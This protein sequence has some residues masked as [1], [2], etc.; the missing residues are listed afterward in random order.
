MVKKR[1]RFFCLLGVIIIVSVM[2]TIMYTMFRRTQHQLSVLTYFIAQEASWNNG[3]YG[4]SYYKDYVSR[5]EYLEINAFKHHAGS[6]Y[7]VNPSSFTI[8]MP[9]IYV[10]PFIAV[11]SYEYDC[12]YCDMN[13]GNTEELHCICHV[14]WKYG[15]ENWELIGYMEEETDGLPENISQHELIELTYKIAQE[16]CWNCGRYDNSQFTELLSEKNYKKLSIFHNLDGKKIAAI[17]IY[18]V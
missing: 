10:F 8:T 12:T 17:L 9:K 2:Y 14:V 18:L 11:A 15:G 4:S 1:R 13:T 3:V 16:S 7:S 6:L 5:S